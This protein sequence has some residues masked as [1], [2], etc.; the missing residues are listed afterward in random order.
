MGEGNVVVNG[1]DGNTYGECKDKK[2]PHD[3]SCPEI[4]ESKGESKDN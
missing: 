3:C 4:D 2:H 1:N